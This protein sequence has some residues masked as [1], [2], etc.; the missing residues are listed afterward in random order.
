MKETASLKQKAVPKPSS[1][2]KKIKKHKKKNVLHE[3]EFL[4]QELPELY[5]KAQTIYSQKVIFSIHL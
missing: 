5:T 1:L 2:K 4:T 3:K